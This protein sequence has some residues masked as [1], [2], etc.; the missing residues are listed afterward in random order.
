MWCLNFDAEAFLAEFSEV[1]IFFVAE[2][3][4]MLN[5]NLLKEVQVLFLLRK[6]RKKMGRQTMQ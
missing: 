2:Q 3:K 4:S 1:I 5:E 6:E